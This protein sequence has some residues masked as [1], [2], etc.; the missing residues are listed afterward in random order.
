MLSKSTDRSIT[1]EISV[2]LNIST[3][4]SP[5]FMAFDDAVIASMRGSIV[6]ELQ[7]VDIF[8]DLNDYMFARD[9]AK[10]RG[11]RICIDGLTHETLPFVDR[12]KLGADMVKLIWNSDIIDNVGPKRAK[13]LIKRAG[14]S[15]VIFCRCDEEAAVEFGQEIGVNMFQGRFIENLIA[16]ESRRREMEMAR[17][18]TQNLDFLDEGG[19]E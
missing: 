1:G 8:S 4:L 9:F 7:K 16:E 15:K 13:R 12:E 19:D 10:E 3:L 2:N 14:A 5:E 6:I 18:R 17:R 11:Y